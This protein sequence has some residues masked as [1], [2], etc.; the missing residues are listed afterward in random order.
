MV[1]AAVD[2]G[3]FLSHIVLEIYSK[4]GQDDNNSDLDFC[5]VPYELF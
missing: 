2:F 5:S 4:V 1:L 3:R